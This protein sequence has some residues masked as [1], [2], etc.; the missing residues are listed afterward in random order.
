MSEG[1][2]IPRKV[3]PPTTATGQGSALQEALSHH[4]TAA[5]HRMVQGAGKPVH[6][7]PHMG[8]FSSQVKPHREAMSLRTVPGI[9]HLSAKNAWEPRRTPRSQEEHHGSP[10][11]PPQFG[12]LLAM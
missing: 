10:D 1:L 12:A 7:D 6:I 11:R 2:H 8:R 9:V 3:P 5:G 4:L